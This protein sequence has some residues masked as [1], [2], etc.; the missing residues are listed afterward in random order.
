MISNIVPQILARG[1]AILDDPEREAWRKNFRYN[2]RRF[3]KKQKWREQ[4]EARW[5]RM[6]NGDL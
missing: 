3:V 4:R 5:R 6:R 1:L 2:L